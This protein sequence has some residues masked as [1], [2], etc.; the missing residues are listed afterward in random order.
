MKGQGNQ[1]EDQLLDV[2]EREQV[3]PLPGHISDKV[4]DKDLYIQAP[5]VKKK[6]VAGPKELVPIK[7]PKPTAPVQGLPEQA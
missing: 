7:I 4:M 6:A 2:Q 1:R 5:V 3:W